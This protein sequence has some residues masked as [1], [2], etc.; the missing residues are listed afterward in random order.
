MKAEINVYV[1]YKNMD[2]V[3]KNITLEDSKIWIHIHMED[4]KHM[5]YL[6]IMMNLKRPWKILDCFHL[7][8]SSIRRF[9]KI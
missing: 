4:N 8:I 3:S 6:K 2:I 9:I 1:T 7:K 5:D